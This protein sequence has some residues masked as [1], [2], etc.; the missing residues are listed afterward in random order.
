MMRFA[1]DILLLR[2]IVAK[3]ARSIGGGSLVCWAASYVFYVATLRFFCHGSWQEY[4]VRPTWSG[5][6]VGRTQPVVLGRQEL[7]RIGQGSYVPHE[8]FNA[9][10]VAVLEIRE[11]GPA[12]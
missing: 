8:P 6:T 12:W 5:V 3:S 1:A 7:L 9:M 11:L 4:W 10:P 2:Q